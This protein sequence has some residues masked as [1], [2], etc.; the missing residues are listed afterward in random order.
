MDKPIS[1]KKT[2]MICAGLWAAFIVIELAFP[3]PMSVEE[4]LVMEMP[5][6]IVFV[7]IHDRFGETDTVSYQTTLPPTAENLWLKGERLMIKSPVAEQE[8]YYL[9]AYK[10]TDRNPAYTLTRGEMY[11]SRTLAFY[12]KSYRVIVL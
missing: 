8:V 11:N 3:V 5:S 2:L 12:V 1:W 7:E 10:S 6:Q 9:R 4:M